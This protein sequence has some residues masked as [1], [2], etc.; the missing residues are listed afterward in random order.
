MSNRNEF[1]TS[2]FSI[3][4]SKLAVIILFIVSFDSI[5]PYIFLLRPYLYNEQTPAKGV[6]RVL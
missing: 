3:T 2:Q 6:D 5:N 4:L 1:Q